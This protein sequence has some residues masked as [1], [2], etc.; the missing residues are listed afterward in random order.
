MTI[1]ASCGHCIAIKISMLPEWQG[2]LP[3]LPNMH[4]DSSKHLLPPMD[5]LLGAASLARHATVAATVKAV[6]SSD[7]SSSLRHP[8]LSRRTTNGTS[9][10]RLRNIR[11]Q[12]TLTSKLRRMGINILVSRRGV[13]TLNA[14]T[15]NRLPVALAVVSE[16]C[17]R[18]ALH[19]LAETGVHVSGGAAAEGGCCGGDAGVGLVVVAVVGDGGDVGDV[20]GLVGVGGWCAA[21]GK[22]LCAE[23]GDGVVADV[24]AG[25]VLGGC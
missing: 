1:S 6:L 14:T 11:V 10:T 12:R 23:F 21:W 22:G 16:L 19:R 7:T 20:V 3:G 17:A 24:D 9:L 5:S 13:Q 8:L 15:A 25:L 18:L 4:R 2:H